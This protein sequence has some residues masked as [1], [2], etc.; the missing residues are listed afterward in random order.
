[1]IKIA[2]RGSDLAIWQAKRIQ[3]VLLQICNEPSEL[4]IIKTQGDLIQG[5]PLSLLDGKGFFTKEIE[6]ALLDH[7]ADIAVHSLKDLPTTLPPGLMIGAIPERSLVHDQLIILPSAY[8]EHAPFFLTSGSLLGTSS[9]RRTEQAKLVQ[10][11]IAIK[12]IRGNVPT[13]LQK[14][15][16][17]EYDAIL[18]AAAGI[19][20]LGLDVSD[21]IVKDLS[22]ETFLPAPGQGALAIEIRENDD[23]IRQI[24]GKLH[25][26]ELA[27]RIYEERRFLQLTEGGCHASVGS[28]CR[29]TSGRV[30][31]S[32]YW[33]DGSTTVSLT[34][35]GKEAMGLAE[36]SFNLHQVV[37]KNHSVR[38]WKTKINTLP[39]ALDALIMTSGGTVL[40]QP[41][42]EPVCLISEKNKD[43]IQSSLKTSD[44]L[45]LTSPVA[46][47]CLSD[48]RLS[49]PE[50]I[51]IAVIGPTTERAL[52]QMFNRNP[53][54][55]S[56]GGDGDSLWSDLLTHFPDANNFF[57]PASELADSLL[58]Q[59]AEKLK[60]NFIRKNIYTLKPVTFSK[61]EISKFDPTCV[62][63]YSSSAVPELINLRYLLN[64]N[65]R[66][67]AIGKQTEKTLR[68]HG[69]STIRTADY[70]EPGAIA[71][72]IYFN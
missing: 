47:K 63:V 42:I 17:G 34:L 33:N 62:V 4:Q 65:I 27:D 37:K 7:S 30:A 48:L 35:S 22:P 29:Q 54:W 32:T 40:N 56:S 45:I 64:K 41:L 19:E 72:Q 26:N 43:I 39:D 14:L 61:D 60:K 46:V 11:D 25:R 66:L 55:V 58:E 51:Q 38:V 70:P 49:L 52:S 50:N 20:R 31:L 44:W 9:H 18:L 59:F 10:P 12:V 13:R 71:E 23:R 36:R 21:F 68:L 2:T 8:N 3:Q 1:M 67:I 28:Y 15:R 57:Y 16:N 24:I 53:K 5:V 69:F 6:Q